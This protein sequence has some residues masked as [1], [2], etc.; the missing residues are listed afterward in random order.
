MAFRWCNGTYLKIWNYFRIKILFPYSLS[1]AEFWWLISTVNVRKAMKKK[2]F[3]ISDR[4]GITDVKS[5]TVVNFYTKWWRKE[6]TWFFAKSLLLQIFYETNT[7]TKYVK[8]DCKKESRHS[9]VRSEVT[10]LF[11]FWWNS[12]GSHVLRQNSLFSMVIYL[13]SLFYFGLEFV[14][15]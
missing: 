2:T 5:C 12:L 10:K 11:C 1:W 8:S 3:H 7:T 14:S 13:D 6:S 15:R 4:F 9:K